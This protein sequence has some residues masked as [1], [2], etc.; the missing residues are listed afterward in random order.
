MIDLAFGSR[1]GSVRGLRGPQGVAVAGGSVYV[2]TGDDGKLHQFDTRTLAA[3]KTVAVGDDADNVRVA[4]D[5]TIWVSFGGE[6]PGGLAC[7]DGGSLTLERKLDLPR[8]PEG[9]QLHPSGVG[10]FA[11]LPAGKRSVEDGT[12]VGLKRPNGELLWERKFSGRAGNFPMGL[13]PA[14]DRVFVVTRRPA[15]LISLSMRDG[16]ILGETPCPPESDDLFF[17]A[18]SGLV[19][20]IGGGALPTPGDPGGAGASLDLFAIDDSGRPSR[21]GGTP[22]PAHSRTGALAVDRRMIYVGVPEA[23]GRSAEVR[24]YRLPD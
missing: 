24:E 15:R 3:G 5:G 8:M 13:D 18:Q 21:S 12:V 20:V 9:F 2:T 16:S 11:N 22:L 14:K 10:I 7:F 19:A 23:Q 6:K 4:R 1:A 17:D